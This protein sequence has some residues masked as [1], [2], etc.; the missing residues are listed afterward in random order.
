[1]CTEEAGIAGEKMLMKH[2]GTIKKMKTVLCDYSSI[3][4][5]GWNTTALKCTLHT[6]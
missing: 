2:K 4:F 5:K 6:I 3:L 1:M